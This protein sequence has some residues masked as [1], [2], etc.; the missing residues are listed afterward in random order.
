MGRI[1]RKLDLLNAVQGSWLMS[2][3][4]KRE[5]RDIIKENTMK[6]LIFMKELYLFTNGWNIVNL[7]V[8][9]L[10]YLVKRFLQKRKCQKMDQK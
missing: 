9:Q 1:T 6:L 3:F 5:T 2:N 10:I 7:K 4:G 8:N